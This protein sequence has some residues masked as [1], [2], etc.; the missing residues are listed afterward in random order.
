MT[1]VEVLLPRSL[2][3]PVEVELTRLEE[4]IPTPR[5]M[6]GGSVYELKW[7]EW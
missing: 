2:R 1:G 3:G 7:A 4:T 5:R 6:A